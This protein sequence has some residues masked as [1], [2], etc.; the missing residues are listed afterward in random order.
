V[1]G[2]RG[3]KELQATTTIT[4]SYSWGVKLM[5]MMAGGE[6]TIARGIHLFALRWGDEQG[7]E[8]EQ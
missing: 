4:K 7:R 1:S 5:L 3:R 8:A 2:L 6:N